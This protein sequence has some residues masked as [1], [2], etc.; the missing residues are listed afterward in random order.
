MSSGATCFGVFRDGLGN[1][2]V[3]QGHKVWWVF[4][5][6]SLVAINHNNMWDW[7][8]WLLKSHDH[9]WDTQNVT[10]STFSG[11]RPVYRTFPTI[12]NWEKKNESKILV[13]NFSERLCNHEPKHQK[14]T[15]RI[16][17]PHRYDTVSNLVRII[18]QQENWGI[19]SGS[20]ENTCPD[21]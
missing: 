14:P 12:K 21:K 2:L 7:E 6:T 17:R 19:G 13:M 16:S 10:V 5:D 1:I 4:D 9:F 3:E 18:S 8:S 20:T 11:S 15:T